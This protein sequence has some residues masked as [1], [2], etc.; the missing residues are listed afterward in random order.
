MKSGTAFFRAAACA[1]ACAAAM[2]IIS[3]LCMPA[4]WGAQEEI[5]V[6][7]PKNKQ[8]FEIELVV[9]IDG[10]PFS[11]LEFELLIS[12]EGALS[13]TA[14]EKGDP[15]SGTMDI[16]ITSSHGAYYFGFC[17]DADDFEGGRVAVGTLGVG[18]YAG[19]GKVTLAVSQMKV[20]RAAANNN[21]GT[22][23]LNDVIV[24]TVKREGA[25]YGALPM[26][27]PIPGAGPGAGAQPGPNALPG[28]ETQPGSDGQG[29]QGSQGGQGG[30]DGQG[31]GSQNADGAAT[32]QARAPA[33]ETTGEPEGSEGSEGRALADGQKTS[34]GLQFIKDHVQFINGYSDGAVQ[35]DASLTRAE[36]V[37]IIYRLVDDDGKEAPAQPM[38]SDVSASRWFTHAVAYTSLKGIVQGYR[39]GGFHP[40]DQITRAEF[41]TIMAKFAPAAPAASDA[42]GTSYALD[43]SG[44]SYALDAS[45]TAY[46]LDASLAFADVPAR[47]WASQ[48]I[49]ACAANGWIV[50]YPNGTFQPESPISRAEAVTILNRALGRAIAKDDIPAGVPSYS[51]LP[52]KHWAYAQIIEASVAHEP[53]LGAGGTETWIWNSEATI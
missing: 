21:T 24:F 7:V 50:G 35:P 13:V 43:A 29:G 25:D 9:D 36:A 15:Y 32:T 8:D 51:D 39:D 2:A 19:D 34:F 33:S 12:D 52:T 31:G 49:D 41:S 40:E 3:S 22:Q 44:T 26:P 10:E 38:F 46:A 14:F 42:S 30:Q 27:T 47:H 23:T 28:S 53:T 1:A 20:T 18:G 6:E 11:G 48:Y 5:T 45:G 16:P 4:V 17:S 37:T